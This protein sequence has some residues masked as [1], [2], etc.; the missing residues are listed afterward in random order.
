MVLGSVWNQLLKHSY[1]MS[2]CYTWIEMLWK[3]NDYPYIICND[4]NGIIDSEYF[5]ANIKRFYV[6]LVM[7][8]SIDDKLLLLRKK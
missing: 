6:Q 7:H 4:Q 1:I 8:Y 2:K 3:I 5:F